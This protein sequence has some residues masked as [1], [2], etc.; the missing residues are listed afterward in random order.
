MQRV[1]SEE[2]SVLLIAV[3]NRII[4]ADGDLPGAGDLGLSQFVASAAAGNPASVRLFTLGLRQVDIASPKGSSFIDLSAQEQDT[5]LKS[6]ESS[7]PEFF[8]ALVLQT[9]NGYYT[10]QQILEKIGYAPHAPQRGEQP[11]LLDENLLDKQRER[12]PFWTKV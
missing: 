11:E 5:A 12:A 6:V 1:F 8:Q 2:Q 10:H 9:Y 4:P 3:L 7:S